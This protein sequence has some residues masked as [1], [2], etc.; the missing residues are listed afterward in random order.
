[1]KIS[2]N[3]SKGNLLAHIKLKCNECLNLYDSDMTIVTCESCGGTLDV[4]YIS[5]QNNKYQMNLKNGMKMIAPLNNPEK[6]VSLGEG[7]TPVIRF[8]KIENQLGLDKIFGKLEFM[9]PTGSFKDRGTFMMISIA[10]ESNIDS[11]VED[12]S[13][14]AGASL[15]AYCARTGL[16]AH[17]FFL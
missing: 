7:N 10:L 4:E 16:K 3:F 17:I 2:I 11:L 14:N 15:S 5:V 6:F 9:N 8:P 1:M 13:G 12:S